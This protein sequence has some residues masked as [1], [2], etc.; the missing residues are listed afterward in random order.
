MHIPNLLSLQIYEQ[1]PLLL[2]PSV[3]QYDIPV[4]A[5]MILNKEG[6]QV[7]QASEIRTWIREMRL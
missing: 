2:N 1:L 3:Y 4:T 7:R 5:E 6:P